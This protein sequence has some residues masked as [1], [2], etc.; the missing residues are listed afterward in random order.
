MPELRAAPLTADRLQGSP[1]Y[2]TAAQ[3]RARLRAGIRARPGVQQISWSLPRNDLPEPG[4]Q[5]RARAY[6]W[7]QRVLAAAQAKYV[8]PAPPRDVPPLKEPAVSRGLCECGCGGH[9]LIADKTDSRF[10]RVK[11]QPLRFIHGHNR[12]WRAS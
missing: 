11:G 12:A 10:G 3:K 6:P 4:Y 2:Y 1:A 8:T 7:A 9:T 5:W